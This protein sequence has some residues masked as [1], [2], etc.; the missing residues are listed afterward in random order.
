LTKAV[1]LPIYVFGRI[2]LCALHLTECTTY[3]K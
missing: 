1:E 2:T 3:P